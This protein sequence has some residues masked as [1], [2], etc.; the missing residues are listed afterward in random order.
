MRLVLDTNVV[1]SAMLWGGVPHRLLQARHERRI[2]L[3]TSAPQVEG[4]NILQINGSS[5]RAKVEKGYAVIERKWKPGDRIDL[6]LPL[7]IQRVKS[8]PRIESNRDRVALRY[9]PV[10]YNLESVDQSLD[11]VLSPETPLLA[12]WRPDLL[13]GVMV[14]RGEFSNGEPMTAIPN[15]ARLNRGGRSVVWMRDN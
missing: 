4:L 12:E 5:I 1:A 9:G 6:W 14:I 15:Y 11:A 10:V 13:G 8:D 2:E 7:V 3:Y